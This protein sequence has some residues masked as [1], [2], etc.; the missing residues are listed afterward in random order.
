MWGGRWVG[1]NI[2]IHRGKAA[3]AFHT[4][5]EECVSG[6]GQRWG[7]GASQLK[8]EWHCAHNSI[9]GCFLPSG[10]E[11]YE[12]ILK[13][14]KEKMEEDSQRDGVIVLEEAAAVEPPTDDSATM[15]RMAAAPFGTYHPPLVS[16]GPLAPRRRLPS[17]LLAHGSS[18]PTLGHDHTSAQHCPRGCPLLAVVPPVGARASRATPGRDPED[19]TQVIGFMVLCDGD[20]GHHCSIC[21]SQPKP[22]QVYRA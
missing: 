18:L 4:L 21:C 12:K 20:A 1:V 5:L 7:S 19:H 11:K 15:V 3:S 16:F 6:R 2:R 8:W 22:C 14:V 17:A 13:E 10:N 9:C